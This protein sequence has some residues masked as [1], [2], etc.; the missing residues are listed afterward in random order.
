M[1][2]D[3]ADF[4]RIEQASNGDWRVYVWTMDGERHTLGTHSYYKALAIVRGLSDVIVTW[5]DE[6]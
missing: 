4:V 2:I 5:T 3:P 1:R 6:P